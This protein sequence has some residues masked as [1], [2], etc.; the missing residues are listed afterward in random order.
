MTNILGEIVWFIR[1]NWGK[2]V[3]IPLVLVALG[4]IGLLVP[5]M[6]LVYM[7]FFGAYLINRDD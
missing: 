6:F 1:E 7:L 5:W 4:V 3:G 2:I